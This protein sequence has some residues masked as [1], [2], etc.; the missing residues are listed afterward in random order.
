MDMPHVSA[1]ISRITVFDRDATG[2][3][4]PVTIYKRRRR[5]KK[6][7]RG[8]RP[9]ERTTRM[10]ADANDRFTS[11]YTRRH[12]RSNRKRR[13]GWLRDFIVNLSRATNKGRK[14]IK[15]GRILSW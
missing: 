15:P 1:T 4:R 9:L 10:I 11:D 2:S 8:L 7:T 3:L 6:Q 13:D 5:K 12:R 14:E